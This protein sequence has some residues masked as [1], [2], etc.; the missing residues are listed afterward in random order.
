M[1]ALVIAGAAVA[2][3][4]ALPAAA[5]NISGSTT[6]ST[7]SAATGP[8]TSGGSSSGT[9]SGMPHAGEIVKNMKS[10]LEQSGFTHVHVMPE[11]FLVRAQ[12]KDGHPVMMIVNPDS[13]TAVTALNRPGGS[14]KGGSGAAGQGTNSGSAMES[15]NAGSSSDAGRSMN[16]TQSDQLPGNH[17]SGN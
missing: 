7:G 1:K 8:E 6:Q 4:F 3:G 17:E 12:D 15:G 9:S 13:L 16:H 2:L 10:A 14:S 5:Q 11:S